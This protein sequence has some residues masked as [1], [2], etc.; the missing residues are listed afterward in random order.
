MLQPTE[1]PQEAKM[2]KQKVSLSKLLCSHNK[3]ILTI[4]PN[5]TIRPKIIMWAVSHL[6]CVCRARE[7]WSILASKVSHHIECFWKP[8]WCLTAESSLCLEGAVLSYNTIFT[9]A[10]PSKQVLHCTEQHHY[11]LWLEVGLRWKWLR[12]LAHQQEKYRHI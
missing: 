9:R 8:F 11:C 5:A 1:L 12:L 10:S 4:C 7:S 2:Q 6:T 3:N